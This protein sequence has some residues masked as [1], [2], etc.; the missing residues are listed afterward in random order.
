MAAGRAGRPDI[1]E[2]TMAESLEEVYPAITFLS[3]QGQEVYL[4]QQ[5]RANYVGA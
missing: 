2:L 4:P 1:L 3:A 5:P